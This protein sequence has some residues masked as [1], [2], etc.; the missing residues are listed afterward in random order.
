MTFSEAVKKKID[1]RGFSLLFVSEHIE[2]STFK[3][4]RYLDESMPEPEFYIQLGILAAID[5][6]GLPEPPSENT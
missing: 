6:I 3:L 2:C 5:I 4:R 1:R